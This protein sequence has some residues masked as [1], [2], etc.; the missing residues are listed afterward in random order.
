MEIGTGEV[1]F[2]APSGF[3][4]TLKN[5]TTNA[6]VF[7]NV[8]F[9]AKVTKESD[10]SYKLVASGSRTTFVFDSA[11]TLTRIT[12]RNGVGLTYRYETAPNGVQRVASVTDAAGRVTSYG[13]D[14]SNRIISITDSASRVVKYG[15]DAAGRLVHVIDPAGFQVNYSYDAAG[16]LCRI[17]TARGVTVD[18]AYDTTGRVT[19]VSRYQYLQG[20]GAKQTTSFAYASGSTVVTNPAGHTS[21]HTIDG[22]GR[23]TKVV[24]ALGVTRNTTWT[25]SSMVASSFETVS[26]VATKFEWDSNNNPT[27]VSLPTGATS[28]ATYASGACGAGTT[29]GTATDLQQ[30]GSD[31]AGNDTAYSYDAVGNQLSATDVSSSATGG[32]KVTK[33]YAKPGSTDSATN[34]SSFA[35]QLCSVTDGNGHVTRYLYD[36]DGNMVK[37]I[38]PAP[39]GAVT[40]T[41]DSLGRVAAVAK[42]T[43]V[44]NL[45][46]YDVNDRFVKGVY[47]ATNA[48]P[49]TT[50]YRVHDGDGN[51]TSI[52]AQTFV[53]DGQNRLEKTTDQAGKTRW[54][55]FD[56]AGNVTVMADENNVMTR[57][58]YNAGGQVTSAAWQGKPCPLAG[59]ANAN[60]PTGCVKF[61]Y[62]S[63]GRLYVTVYPGNMTTNTTWD[64]AGRMTSVKTARAGT[65]PQTML[66][67]SYSYGG[68]GT[69]DRVNLVSMTDHT[70]DF[71]PAGAV[72][73][74]GY[75]SLRRLTSAVEKNGTA[76][77]AS[78][79]YTYDKA[80]NRLT[81]ALS[82]TL[83][84]PTAGT[85]T[86]TY[87]AAD[88]LAT[89]NGSSAGIG[90]D[91]N[92]DETANPGWPAG[93]VQPR[94]NVKTTAIGDVA[95][96]TRADTGDVFNFTNAQVLPTGTRNL[97]WSHGIDHTW[98]PAGI[99][100]VTNPIGTGVMKM[101]TLPNGQVLGYELDGVMEY[102][103]KDRLGSVLAMTNDAGGKEAYYRYD[104]YGQPRSYYRW[105]LTAKANTLMYAGLHRDY[106]TGLIRMGARWYDPTQGRFTQA[107][108]SGQE[109]HPYL[110]AAGNPVN[111]SDP[112]GLVTIWGEAARTVGTVGSAV[113]G[114]SCGKVIL[115]CT[116]AGGAVGAASGAVGAALDGESVL[117][118]ALTGGLQG[119][120]G[121]YTGARIARYFKNNGI[122]A[123]DEE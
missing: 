101:F 113:I 77:H 114:A 6:N 33:T 83:G 106:S 54:R 98:N 14:S 72:T 10:G 70:G 5:S 29:S 96:M 12:D 35:G 121:G 39:L 81:A 36:V 3:R 43:G 108:P 107:D 49:E 32:A 15:Y 46:S 99:D 92:G 119:A 55:G 69:A 53:Y 34:C 111:L 18:V 63:S 67:Q 95:T 87:N 41:Y 75:D 52:D 45:Y 19:G 64:T 116:A 88:Q 86:F 109:T 47:G 74:Y 89:V 91:A 20:G 8:S 123:V 94:S 104:P 25:T 38:P 100:S 30:C 78:F 73:T 65:T 42:G 90:F 112:S 37:V 84:G 24:D 2:R 44:T 22:Q 40:Y 105:S 27:K 103:H 102:L 23:V 58:T 66:H 11:G 31:D 17:A 76:T 51:L 122:K 120:V 61:G 93:G 56:A 82:G 117:E 26:T 118:G 13:Y 50:Q 1:L 4:V 16:R 68:S 79:G 7:T 9:R 60:L 71:V 85:R 21:T 115:A 80:G 110:Y 28:S 57:Y 62:N 97:T 48:G 59:T